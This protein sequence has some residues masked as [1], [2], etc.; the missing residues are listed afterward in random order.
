MT[1]PKF[2]QLNPF[3]LK[4]S[5]TTLLNKINSVQDVPNCLADFEMLDSQA[6]KTVLSKLLLKELVNAKAEKIPVIC[7]LLEH[8][9]PKEELVNKFW[10]TLKN[11]N[12]NSE[13]KITIINLLRELDADW[14]YETCEEYLGEDS[15]EILDE[16]TKKL[17]NT[18]IINPEVQIDFLDFLASIRVQDKITLLNSFEGDFSDDALAN[19]LI[20]VFVSEPE[21]PEGKEALRILGTTKSQ[22]ALHV[23]EEMSKSA[24]GELSQE[25]RRALSTLKISGIREDNTKEFYKK[26]LSD[27]VPNKFYITYPD[28][29]GDQALI[30]TRKTQDGKIRFVS[31]VTNIETGVKDC[32]GFFEISQ[33]ECD[34]ILERFLRDE[35]TVELPPEA[36]KT[37][38]HNAQMQS[39]LRNGNNWKLPYEYV[40]WSNLLLDIDFDNESIEQIL[41]E[42]ILPQKVD[43]TI[44]PML[45][46]MKISSHWFLDGNYS[47]EF[48]DLVV[49][50]KSTKDLDAL[51]EKYLP[52]VFYAEEKES[53][54]DKLLMSAYIKYSIGKDDEASLVYG[55]SQDENLL[56]ELFN[57]ILKRSIYEYLMT[58]K[59][60]KEMNT[61]NF[62]P[63]EI[64]EKINY[65]EEKW[66]KN[67]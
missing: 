62:T 6:D 24:K 63:D 32:F 5:L 33:F 67:V 1:S 56:A 40:C 8:Y 51:V 49:E 22:L 2:K 54:I 66:V 41:K 48:E 60:N 30:F 29:H 35:K 19:I 20:P 65:V 23:L 14:S 47:D 38:L 26:I 42:Q 15:T 37:I 34:K 53:W 61:E 4:A 31:I 16:N 39:I 18:A 64:D 45:E 9:T 55:L 27:S 21:S 52:N 44:I 10:E 50:M 25:I 3:E 13:V 57:T 12:L 36:F 11:P 7:F 59:Y 17:L 28:G 46:K 58:I 43:K